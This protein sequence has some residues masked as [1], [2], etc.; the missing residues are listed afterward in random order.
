MEKIIIGLTGP[1]GSGKS[2]AAAVAR[3]LGFFTIDADKVAHQVTNQNKNCKAALVAEFGDV[4]DENGALNRKKLA[5]A[6]F[7]NREST[8][9]LNQITLP[10]IMEEI[11]G[12]IKRSGDKI[13][14]DAPTLFEAGANTLCHKVIGVL[15]PT[16]TRLSRI[17]NRDAISKEAALLR[18]NAGKNDEFYRSRCDKILVNGASETEFKAECEKTLSQLTASH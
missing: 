10:F 4:L 17:M 7:K 18:I 12:I 2:T 8:E 11:K 13:L 15:A 14:L 16:D 6:A 3:E 1:T 5:A 9:R